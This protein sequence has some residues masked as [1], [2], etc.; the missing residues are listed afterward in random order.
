VGEMSAKCGKY[1]LKGATMGKMNGWQRR[2]SYMGN[3][4]TDG[5]SP[6]VIG[7]QICCLLISMRKYWCGWI[8]NGFC[9]H[10]GGRYGSRGCEVTDARGGQVS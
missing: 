3:L 8:G 9:M 4:T 5:A 10:T 6:S 1:P 7:L 2:Y